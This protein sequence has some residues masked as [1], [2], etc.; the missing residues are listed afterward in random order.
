MD[1]NDISYGH[2]GHSGV[3]SYLS[4]A[5]FNVQLIKIT[6]TRLDDNEDII[7]FTI[8]DGSRELGTVHVFT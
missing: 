6:K 4:E 3:P 7:N 8:W 1:K 5:P 2:F